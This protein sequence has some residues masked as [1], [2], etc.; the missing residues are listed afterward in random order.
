[1]KGNV[2]FELAVLEPFNTWHSSADSAST[3]IDVKMSYGKV[4]RPE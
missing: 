3:L 2:K 1:M 4:Y